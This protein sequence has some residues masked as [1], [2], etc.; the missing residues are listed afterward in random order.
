MGL[1]FVVVSANGSIFAI[2]S[3]NKDSPIIRIQTFTRRTDRKFDT[4]HIVMVDPQTSCPFRFLAVDPF[5]DGIV[6]LVG[7][8]LTPHS[9]A[10]VESL[11]FDALSRIKESFKPILGLHKFNQVLIT[12]KACKITL[13]PLS[14]RARLRRTF[15]SRLSSQRG[16]ELLDGHRVALRCGTHVGTVYL[17]DFTDRMSG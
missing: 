11:D 17:F 5:A 4:A 8:Q 10:M 2:L 16:L 7:V 13:P 12:T 14:K 1:L 3:Y 6:S 9:S 15:P